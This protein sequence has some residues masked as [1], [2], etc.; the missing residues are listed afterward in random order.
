MAQSK[1][2][3]RRTHPSD[4]HGHKGTKQANKS[5]PTWVG[6]FS[7]YSSLGV[8][9][10]LWIGWVVSF[11]GFVCFLLLVVVG[12]MNKLGRTFLT[13]VLTSLKANT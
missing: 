1:Y 6:G 4:Q 11:G 7:P 3:K 10:W 5:F 8:E 12:V 2:Y 13:L 9:R